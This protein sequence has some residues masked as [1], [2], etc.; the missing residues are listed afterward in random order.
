MPPETA[1]ILH[2]DI[3]WF[4]LHDEEFVSKTINDSNVDLEE[5]PASKVWQLAKAMESSKAT[6]CH[7]KQVASDPQVVQIN[8]MRQQHTEISS[9]KHKKRNSFVKP[10]QPSHM[11][12]VHEN[13]QTSS[14][15]KK[16]FDPKN[17]RIRI[18]VP[19]MEIPPM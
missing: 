14:C 3:F 2:Q 17:A 16:T 6:A 13:P 5:F 9:G 1:M 7:I 4:F 12:A 18:G 19:S 11:N 8:L 10:K 15:D